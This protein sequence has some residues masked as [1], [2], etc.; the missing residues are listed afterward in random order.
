MRRIFALAVLSLSPAVLHAQ[1]T[2][3]ATFGTAIALPG[4][5]PSDIV[6]DE[7]RQRIYLVN[8]QN[9]RIDIYSI[10]TKQVIS[11]VGVGKAPLAAAMSMD[12]STLY[13]TNSASSS[14][15]VIDLG[16]LRVTQ[17]VSLPAVPEGVEVG[18]DG[19]ALI[20]TQATNS[21]LIFDPT[22]S[23]GLQ[24]TPVLTPPPPSTPAPLQPQTLTRPQTTFNSKLI[25]TPDGQYIIGL[26]NPGNNGSQTYLFV[27]E[28]LSGTILRSRTVAGQSTV[29]S[30]A[31]DGSRFMAGYTMYDTATLSVIAQAEQ[32]QRAFHFRDCV[33]AAA[34][35]RR[36]RVHAGWQ[37]HLRRF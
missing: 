19:R 16:M 33:H 31:P 2:T 13:V 7:L 15:S 23:L 26:T 6:L 25:R 21:L 36:Q 20:G 14:V 37:H 9:N 28:V 24:L 17:T 18:V 34:E 10:S 3:A 35:C 4:G 27:Y 8:S 29:L 32:C 30:I 11:N 1:L 12:G 22:Q 5:T